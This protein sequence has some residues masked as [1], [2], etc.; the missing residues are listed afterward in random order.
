MKSQ[1]TI[2]FFL[3]FAWNY[4]FAQE[5]NEKPKGDLSTPYDALYCFTYYLDVDHY[6]LKK[7]TLPFYK[8]GADA[9]ELT[10][11]LKQILDGKSLKIRLSMVPEDAEYIDSVSKKNVYIP[12][13]KDF[14]EIYIE[15]NKTT[16]KWQFSRET[17]R[18]IPVLHKKVYP[19]G[20]HL[21]LGLL[22]Q[23]GQDIF[24]GLALW[25]YL[26]LLILIVLGFLLN[27]IAYRF[28]R[29]LINM[30][31]N[32]RF[33]KDHFD[34]AVVKRIAHILS[35]L[36]LVYAIYTFVPVVQ[37]P[38]GFGFYLLQVLR[39]VTTLL[40]VLLA[41][42]TVSLFRSYLEYLTSQTA[43]TVD[44]QLL[45]I[46]IR[47]VNVVVIG[48]GFMNTL[49]ILSFNV[50][51]LVAGLSIGGLAIA[52]AAQET[53]KNLIGSV[54]IY[55]DRPFKIGDYVS[56]GSVAGTVV[57][58][59]FR[60][61]RIRTPD[62]SIISVPNGNMMNET[63]NNLGIRE[64][65][66][67]NINIGVTYH[68]PPDLLE[69]YIKGLREM[70]IFHPKID[71]E[72]FY[73]HLHDLN[74]SSIDILF[75]VYF[76]TNNRAEELRYKEEIIFAILRLAES[77][78]VQIAYPSTSVYIETMPEKKPLVPDY[79]EELSVAE[80]QLQQYLAQY[81]EKVEREHAPTIEEPPLEEQGNL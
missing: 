31:A 81:R 1:F 41:L 23:M 12:F 36:L 18:E 65:R 22:P 44:E 39:L 72:L 78:G 27:F 35:Y 60:S 26:A 48:I 9:Q 4:T 47:V 13:P 68:T 57:D 5:G 69:T 3:I 54:M 76:L 30:A 61:T 10:L 67:M 58:I 43:T 2:L 79:K 55:A 33:G 80:Q 29:F 32:S 37:L 20:S 19:L 45:P 75:I 52:L 53:V 42:R 50:T 46:A 8:S 62:T 6:D 49:S 71:S 59:G 70:V 63:I 64:K 7:A 34:K 15:R 74:A 40:V 21:L 25:Q 38:S 28:F 51:A 16:Q 56:V 11:Q 17:E 14:P 24:L 77:L 66:R 73:V